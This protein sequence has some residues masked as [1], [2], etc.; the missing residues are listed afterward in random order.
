MDKNL[1]FIL[2]PDEKCG[3]LLKHE[4]HICARGPSDKIPD[5]DSGEEGSTPFGRTKKNRT[6]IVGFCFFV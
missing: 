6:H 2:I 1:F 3:I 4:N 5:S